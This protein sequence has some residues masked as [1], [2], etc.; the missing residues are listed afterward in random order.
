MNAHFFRTHLLLI[1]GALALAAIFA[2]NTGID[3]ATTAAFYDAAMH[4]FP[5][6]ASVA[7]ELFGHRFAKTAVTMVWVALLAVAAGTHLWPTWRPR[8]T[9]RRAALWAAVIGMALGPTIV[10]ALKDLNSYRCPWDL[11]EFGGDADFVSTW[12]VATSEI[13]H[14]FPGGHAASGFCLA[15]LHFLG[16]ALDRPRFAQFALGLTLFAGIGFSVVRIAQGAHFLSH[17]LWAA[18][19]CW[20]SAALAFLPLNL[21]RTRTVTI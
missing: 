2:R 19:I 4:R 8:L 14:C 9:A 13:G 1:P 15:A 7:L 10:V 5:A 16:C 6:H 11:R 3:H 21:Q 12:F 20:A 18:A 17:N